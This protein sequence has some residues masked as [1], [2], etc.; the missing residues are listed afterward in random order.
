MARPASACIWCCRPS[1]LLHSGL[2]LDFWTALKANLKVQR[3]ALLSFPRDALLALALTCLLPLL[4]ISVRWKSQGAHSGDDNRVGKLVTQTMFR[5]AHAGFL[6]VALWM[7]LDP[8]L[9]PRHLG[10]GMPL[11]T[12]YYL[13]ALV[14]GYCSGYFLLIGS[15][16]APRAARP[17]KLARARQHLATLTVAAA[18]V[19]LAALPL[20]LVWRNLGQI[21]MT[22]GPAVR[23]FARQLCRG[24]PAGRSVV[25]SDDPAQLLL[26][27]AELSAR[28]QGKD[29]LLLDMH[30]LAWGQYQII[31]ARQSKSGWPMAPPTNALELMDSDKLLRLIAAFSRQEQVVYLHPSFSRCFELF[32]DRPNGPVHYLVPPPSDMPSQALDGRSAAANEQYWLELWG[33]TLQPLARQTSRIPDAAPQPAGQ[34]AA[35]LKLAAEQNPTASFLGDAYSKCLNDWGVRMQQLGRWKEAGAWFQHALELNPANLAAQ[36]NLEFNQRCRDGNRQRLDLE[37]VQKRF[38]DLFARHRKWE[39]VINDDGPVDEPTFLFETARVL[40]VNGNPH[41]A[42][43]AFARC[44]DLA[45]D[46]LEPKL[47]LAQAHLAVREFASALE[48]T[49]G[50]AVSGLPQDGTGSAQFLFCRA[51]ALGGLGRTNE[52]AACI[53]AFVAQHQEQAEVL[54]IAAQLYLQSMQYPPA[55]AVLDRLLHR[56]PQNPELLSNKALAEMQL[57]RYDAAIATLTTALSLAPSNQVVQLNRAIACLRAGQLEAA[58]ADYQQ[59]LLTAPNS[60]KVL[61]GLAEIAWR[62]QETNAAILFY[63]KCLPLGNP[64]SAEYRVAASRLRQLKGKGGAAAR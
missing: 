59:L 53:D 4:V 15:V 47:W 50:M 32:T 39:A 45:P 3:G 48:L 24:L 35:R 6:G 7:A 13:S 34:L 63:E 26:L 23:Q 17:H 49:D 41:Q 55:L 10:S 11:L 28:T 25:L 44:A 52:A 2:T 1:T 29:A 43:R 20:A 21:R 19:L 30:S 56:E 51:T 62:R 40:L 9:S 31:K 16:C 61:F 8:P 54:S 58:S 22:N 60:Y 46:W 38:L 27:Q 18:W 37:S 36:I 33:D 12:Q 57:A 14:I 42:I 64:A 5:L